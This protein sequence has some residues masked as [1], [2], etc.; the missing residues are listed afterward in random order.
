MAIGS[1]NGNLTVLKFYLK[2]ILTHAQ[3][4]LENYY[5]S[6]SPQAVLQVHDIHLIS[7]YWE[8]D[9]YNVCVCA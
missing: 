1:T 7:V 2:L 5:L 9:R 6:L 3:E 4:Q 8:T